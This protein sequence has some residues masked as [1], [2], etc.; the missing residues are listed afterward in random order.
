MYSRLFI[1]VSLHSMADRTPSHP[2]LQD[3]RHRLNTN[4]HH[5]NKLIDAYE[6]SHSLLHRCERY[7]WDEPLDT[8]RTEDSAGK[9]TRE[10]GELMEI[11]RKEFGKLRD[12]YKLLQAEVSRP[13]P[14]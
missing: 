8:T 13:F 5:Q 4:H 6:K 14:S 1:F 3:L 9:I 7:L 2:S 11:S 12:E 10:L